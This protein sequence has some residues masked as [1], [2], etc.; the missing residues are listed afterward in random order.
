MNEDM[1]V[2][3]KVPAEVRLPSIVWL[4][5][6]GQCCGVLTYEIILCVKVKVQFTP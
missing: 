5:S 1:A 3:L 2:A 6:V 4:A